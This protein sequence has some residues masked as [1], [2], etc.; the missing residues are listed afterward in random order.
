MASKNENPRFAVEG[1]TDSDTLNN[2]N[3]LFEQSQP[4]PKQISHFLAIALSN[5]E[6]NIHSEED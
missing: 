3:D 6:K 1:N 5:L 2:S 4:M